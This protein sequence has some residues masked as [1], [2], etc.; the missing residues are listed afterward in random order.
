MRF[1]LTLGVSALQILFYIMLRGSSP[2]T[3]LSLVVN[4]DY[5]NERVNVELALSF[6]T[7]WL[8]MVAA[9]TALN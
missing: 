4:C 7:T 3:D 6:C 5:V 9:Y 1:G 2:Y 8:H